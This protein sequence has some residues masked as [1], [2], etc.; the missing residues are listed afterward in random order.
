MRNKIIENIPKISLNQSLSDY[1]EIITDFY[2]N[3]TSDRYRKERGQYFTPKEISQLMIKQ[4]N[5]IDKKEEIKIL[6]P[7]AGVGIFESVFCEHI[8]TNKN[9]IKKIIFDLYENDKKLSVLLD[10]NLKTCKKFMRVNDIEFGY[11]I[12]N[13][14]FILSND[15]ILNNQDNS[16]GTYDFVICNPPYFKIN[17]NSLYLQK[18]NNIINFPPN[19]Y[20]IFMALSGKLLKNDGQMTILTPRSYCS[21]WFFKNFRKLFF[22]LVKPCKI[23]LF[24]SRE[25]V[26]KK[27]NVIQENII[28][29]AIKT[30]RKPKYIFISLSD[31]IPP[32]HNKP[33]IRRTNYEKVIVKMKGDIQ[34]RI[35]RSD[36]D[37]SIA[38]YIDNEPYNLDSL[39]FKV[40]T[41]PVVPFRKKDLLS[42]E[43]CSMGD[44]V[45]LIWM[46]NI[47]QGTVKWPI[48]KKG[49]SIAIM[50][51]DKS[52]RILVPNKN[53]ILVKRFSNK[54][55][56]QRIYAGIYFPDI[57]NSDVVGIE[58]HVNYIYKKNNK[59]D[60]DEL[61]GLTALLNSR[62]YNR[63]LQMTNGSTQVNASEINQL[64]IPS[65]EILKSIGYSTKNL[66]Q[67]NN[68]EQEKIIL[69]LLKIDQQTTERLIESEFIR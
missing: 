40:A 22:N 67:I 43:L 36:L 5:K 68:L 33:K 66:A 58:N 20:P 59:I 30:S 55:G 4:F 21:G 13:E 17:K 41:G 26:F 45:P 39:G 52:R 11:K 60:I 44:F 49:K 2:L 50:N 42:K 31:G 24:N 25:H 29:T 69:N 23:H 61:Y 37:E 28:L 14:D 63:Y 8:L 51:S 7:G 1:T 12:L 56:K 57:S 15:S 18:F 38:F 16:L 53:Y 65:Y 62:L 47:V 9:M 27:Y 19:I 48:Q 10:I 32:E 64:P 46:H 6:D 35:P 3:N 54:E 34:M